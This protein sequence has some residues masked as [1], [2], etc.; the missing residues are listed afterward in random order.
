ML[1]LPS[2]A[3][4]PFFQVDILKSP[5]FH[6][7]HRPFGGELVIAAVGDARTIHLGHPEKVFHHLRVLEGLGLD[8][9]QGVQIDFVAFCCLRE[10]SR[11][12]DEEEGRDHRGSLPEAE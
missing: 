12:E 6:L 11:W 5:L 7:L 10:G 4:R 8:L 9:G 2:I 3:E 1:D